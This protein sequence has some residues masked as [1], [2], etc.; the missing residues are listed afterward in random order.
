MTHYEISL[1]G[2]LCGRIWMPATL[3]GMDLSVDLSREI[4]RFTDKPT[5]RELLLH[6]LCE[7]G[8]D[9]QSASFTCD[10][11]IVVRRETL[12]DGR[13]KVVSRSWPITAFKSV[14]DMVEADVFTGDYC[15]DDDC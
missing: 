1:R 14:S 9:F 2:G 6:V 8:G 10:T 5:L 15:S 13:R 12:S 7:H 11:E 4:D 3:A